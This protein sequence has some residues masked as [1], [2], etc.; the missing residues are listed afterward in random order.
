MNV[1]LP[2]RLLTRAPE[3]LEFEVFAEHVTLQPA[4]N[5]NEIK[6]VPRSTPDHRHIEILQHGDNI[7]FGELEFDGSS[8]GLK[9][10]VEVRTQV[11][12]APPFCARH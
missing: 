3:N 10:E 9:A 12:S 6:H 2:V 11:C 5:Y 7:D 8:L 4:A 1:R